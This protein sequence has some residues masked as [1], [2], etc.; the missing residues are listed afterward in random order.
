MPQPRDRKS[1][2]RLKPGFS[3]PRKANTGGDQTSKAEVCLPEPPG[4]GADDH[5]RERDAWDDYLDALGELRKTQSLRDAYIAAA[6]FWRWL[7]IRR[8]G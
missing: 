8:A 1:R 7:S 4:A 2:V 3:A 6:L 5:N